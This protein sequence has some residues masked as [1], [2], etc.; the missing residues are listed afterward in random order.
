MWFSSS[1]GATDTV[2]RA[3]ETVHLTQLKTEI[4]PARL[5]QIIELVL[6]GIHAARRDLVQ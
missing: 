1:H 3:V 6:I 2:C 4:M 5:R